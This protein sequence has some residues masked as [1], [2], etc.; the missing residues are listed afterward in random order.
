[1]SSGKAIYMP[2]NVCVLK[3]T[4][5]IAADKMED[6]ASACVKS[7]RNWLLINAVEANYNNGDKDIQK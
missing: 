5:D 4:S 1:M 6:F 3:A 2:G 7:H